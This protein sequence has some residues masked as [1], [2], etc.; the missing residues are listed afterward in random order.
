MQETTGTRIV[1]AQENLSD[2]LN[3]YES[4]LEEHYP[5]LDWSDGKINHNVDHEK[6][7]MVARAGHLG[8]FTARCDGKL[9]GYCSIIAD[10]HIHHK[11][12]VFA[13]TD[14]FYLRRSYRKGFT[15][16]KFLNFIQ[17]KL[18]ELGVDVFTIQ[19]R[20]KEKTDKLLKRLGYTEVETVYAKIL[21]ENI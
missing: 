12:I 5:S 18:K 3:E 4:V 16:V 2:I 8:L 13:T 20:T 9:V 15:G 10:N 21:K 6:Y 1:F 11:D 7:G 17:E 19:S 14:S